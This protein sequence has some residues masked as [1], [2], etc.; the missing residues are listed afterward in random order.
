[1]KYGMAILTLALITIVARAEDATQF[2][3]AGGLGVSKETDLPTKWSATEGLRWKASLPGKGL[4]NPVVAGGRVYVTVTA[5]FEQ[6]RE[7]VL[8]FDVRTGK[9]LWERQVWATG[10]TLCH[11]K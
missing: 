9:K 6:K 1:M 11:P 8:C 5:A 3:G 4:S 2:R 10:T 7:A